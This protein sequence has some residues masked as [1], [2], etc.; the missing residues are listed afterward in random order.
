MGFAPRGLTERRWASRLS[1]AS[2]V[3]LR[4]LQPCGWGQSWRRPPQVMCVTD[5]FHFPLIVSA[6]SP[7][8]ITIPTTGR[9][10]LETPVAPRLSPSPPV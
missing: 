9:I 4:K 7:G 6:L 8:E 2:P 3:M 1:G 10:T 5:T